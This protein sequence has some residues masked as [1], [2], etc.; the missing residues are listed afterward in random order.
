MAI[1]TPAATGKRPVEQGTYITTRALYR[2]AIAQTES[3]VTSTGIPI[4]D[5]RP[6]PNGFLIPAGQANTDVNMYGKDARINLSVF[7]SDLTNCTLQLWLDSDLT[8]PRLLTAADQ[9]SSSY[10]EPNLPTTGSWVLVAARTFT[11][12]ALWV[13]TDIPPGK[14]RVLLTAWTGSSGS[15]FVTLMEQHAA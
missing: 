10:S 5:T 4:I 1:G 7:P 6:G 3:D 13:I 15:S 2:D 14:Y 12:P 11:V 9:S 8:A